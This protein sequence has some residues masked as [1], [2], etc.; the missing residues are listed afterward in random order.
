M[1]DFASHMLSS[2]QKQKNRF[3]GFFEREKHGEVAGNIMAYETMIKFL[4]KEIEFRKS[5]RK[6]KT[7][8]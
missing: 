1:L 3:G 2:W 5:I 4:E 6:D 7:N 8:E